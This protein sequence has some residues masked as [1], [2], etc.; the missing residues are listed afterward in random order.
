MPFLSHLPHTTSFFPNREYCTSRWQ[1]GIY[2]KS[3]QPAASP[4]YPTSGLPAG[5]ASSR[6]SFLPWPLV[7]LVD[8]P[9]LQQQG[10]T[11]IWCQQSGLHCAFWKPS[12]VTTYMS[13]AFHSCPLSLLS[14]LMELFSPNDNLE[15]LFRVFPHTLLF[16]LLGLCF[17]QQPLFC[18]IFY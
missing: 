16:Q 12:T 7:S 1:G 15:L 10:V 14:S 13:L 5:N 4:V 2:W 9:C 11:H 6:A 8:K 3:P 17:F 18:F